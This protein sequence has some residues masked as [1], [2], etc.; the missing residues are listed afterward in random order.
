MERILEE[1]LNRLL[2]KAPN[3]WKCGVCREAFMG[4]R[5]ED[6]CCP[7]CRGNID[8]QHR[9]AMPKQEALSRSR[10]PE[11]YRRDHDW[12]DSAWPRDPRPTAKAIDPLEWPHLSKDQDAVGVP[13][14][15]T[16]ASE[17]GTGKS[18]RA[19]HLLF[20]FH[21]HDLGRLLWVREAELVEESRSFPPHPL[22]HHAGNYGA[23]VLDDIGSTRG[24]RAEEEAAFGLVLEIIEQRI[25]HR[26]PLVLTTH[27]PLTTKVAAARGID[28]GRAL[29]VAAPAIYDRMTAGLLI[30]LKGTSHRGD[31]ARN[32]NPPGAATDNPRNDPET[33]GEE[34]HD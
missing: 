6:T 1:L 27:W 25:Q 12:L 17:N 7:A 5:P 8:R 21:R 20:L 23:V 24:T 9:L 19:A 15:L 4:T 22:R 29:A 30:G 13:S 26:R 11:E 33:S 10:V 34:K 31:W 28:R 18:T 3:T 2:T 16:F 14:L 32:A